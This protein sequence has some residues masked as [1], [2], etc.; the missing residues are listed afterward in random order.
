[1]AVFAARYRHSE[2]IR[3]LSYYSLHIHRRIA[4]RPFQSQAAV[5]IW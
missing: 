4:A 2:E 5:R 3:L 1:M